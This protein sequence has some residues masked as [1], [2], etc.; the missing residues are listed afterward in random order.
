MQAQTDQDDDMPTEIDFAKGTRG[1]FFTPGMTVNLP[2]EP[3]DSSA[4]SRSTAP[5]VEAA[6]AAPSNSRPPQ[7]PGAFLTGNAREFRNDTIGFLTKSNLALGDLFNIRLGPRRMTVACHPDLAE[8][9][10]I[11][12][13]SQWGKLTE[14][15]GRATRGLP[16]VLGMGL[17]TNSGAAWQRQRRMIQPV[18]HR[19]QIAQMAQT[20]TAAGE[21]LL[22]RWDAEIGPGGRIDLSE[23]MMK[24]TVE[25]ISETMFGAD[26]AHSTD[27][28]AR[29]MPVLLRF[30]FESLTNPLTPPPS[31]PTPRNREFR[32][33]LAELDG[34]I[35]GLIE[36]RSLAAENGEAPRGDLLDLLLAARDSAGNG[37]AEESGDA[38]AAQRASDG[39]ADDPASALGMSTEQLR[40]EVT[41]I[42]G[43]GHETTANALAWTFYLL[44]RNDEVR[45]RLGD[46]LKTRLNGRTPTLADL[47]ALRYTRAVLDEALRLYPP[48][49]LLVRVALGPTTLG[50]CSFERGDRVLVAV[51][52]IHRHPD[53]WTDPDRFDPGRFLAA[54]TSAESRHRCAYLPFGAGQRVCI[55]NH[56]A[57]M[58]GQLLLAQIA[59]R[60]ELR[61]ASD[62]VV[63]PEVAVT[64]RPKF[65]MAMTLA[66]H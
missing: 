5:V 16:M 9:V 23:E 6:A 17:V 65:G 39:H 3:M 18:F 2:S 10:L 30:A 45:E 48:A 20:M 29:R 1:K 15:T 64:M 26:M 59:Q 38:A 49:P 51:H 25:I 50:G 63:V 12:G 43:A 11:K 8:Q 46:E 28:L 13:R 4:E 53:F 56:F 34:L 27:F 33:A 14:L 54:A 21:R 66:P 22:A 35:Y 40:D 57:L 31:W 7:A 58:E 61:L 32:A 55:G 62:A 44:S 60:H 52:R 36:R 19:S 47:P 24:V 41:T 37:D 42:F